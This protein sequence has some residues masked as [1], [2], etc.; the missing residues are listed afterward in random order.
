M[1]AYI[2]DGAK[3]TLELKGMFIVQADTTI[4]KSIKESNTSVL[5]ILG[6]NILALENFDVVRLER[7]DGDIWGFITDIEIEKTSKDVANCQLHI[8]T[9]GMTG[10]MVFTNGTQQNFGADMYLIH[11]QLFYNTAPHTFMP[12]TQVTNFSGYWTAPDF[13]LD[14]AQAVR[15]LFRQGIKLKRQITND[16][17]I[18]YEPYRHHA[19]NTD[20][21]KINFDGVL[22]Y[23]I[24]YTKDTLTSIRCYQKAND[25]NYYMTVAFMHE[26]GTVSYYEPNA[27]GIIKPIKTGT[28]IFERN[29]DESSDAFTKRVNN[30]VRNELVTQ[31]YNNSIEMIVNMETWIYRDIFF[32]KNEDLFFSLGNG[33]TLTLPNGN[34]IKTIVSEISIT[35]NVATIR[36]GLGSTRLFEILRRK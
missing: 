3:T 23:S 13:T 28:M 29:E 15:Q 31:S 30:E 17:R 27:P 25:I 16:N 8:D 4:S 6:D 26:D 36:F 24:S 9:D 32:P 11:R 1:V 35:D 18:R 22:D 33:G 34:K 12:D 14:F 2:F 20:Q 10:E 7:S 19:Q 5:T 21:F